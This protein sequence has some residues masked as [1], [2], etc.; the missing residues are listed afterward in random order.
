MTLQSQLLLNDQKKL[1]SEIPKFTCT[2]K[3]E[4]SQNLNPKQWT[5]N[6]HQVRIHIYFLTPSSE[7]S[8]SYIEIITKGRL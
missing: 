4:N 7:S 3:P 1:N 8:T 5:R 2:S 6:P